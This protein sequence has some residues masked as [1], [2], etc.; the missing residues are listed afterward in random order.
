M[1]AFIGIGLAVF[2]GLLIHAFRNW[3]P[4]KRHV[5]A[6]AA[7]SFAITLAIFVMATF[8]PHPITTVT[9]LSLMLPGFA[10]LAL[11]YRLWRTDRH[12]F[13]QPSTGKRELD[14][15]SLAARFEQIE[16]SIESLRT[17]LQ[18]LREAQ[19]FTSRLVDKTE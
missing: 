14:G 9:M 3:H 4:S 1:I 8:P 17:D 19:E 6:G 15:E 7:G 12:S 5:L 11:E 16:E 13:M 18:H 10:F 2:A